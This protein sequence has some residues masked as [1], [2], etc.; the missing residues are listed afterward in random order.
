MTEPDPKQTAR[1]LLTEAHPALVGLSHWIHANPELGYEEVLAAGWI[2]DWMR[3]AGFYVRVGVAGM[4]TALI[5]T[6]GAGRFHVALCAEYDALPAVG[7]ACGHN[8]I[9]AS[10][11]GAAVALAAVADELDL[12]VTLFGTPAEEGGG[13]KIRLIEAGEFEGVHAAL[14]VHPGPD[15]ILEPEI[16]GVRQ[17]T[18]TYTGREA[19]AAAFPELGVNAADAL[20]IAQVAIGALRQHI[21]AGD[22]IHGIVTKGGDAPNIVPAHTTAAY[23][24]RSRT[25]DGLE[26]L[27][28]RV[29]RCFEAGALA[30]GCELVIQR[31]VDYLPV[32]HD[33]DLIEL[34]ARNAEEIGRWFDPSARLVASTD[35]GDVSHVVPS[36]HPMIGIASRPAVNHQPAFADAAVAHAADQAV[37]DG[38]LLLAW[39]AI[40]AAAS[41]DLRTR[42]TGLPARQLEEEAWVSQ[43]ETS[44]WAAAS[45]IEWGLAPDSVDDRRLEFATDGFEPDS[46]S[47]GYDDLDAGAPADGVNAP[48]EWQPSTA[49]AQGP[50]ADSEAPSEDPEPSVP[51]AAADPNRGEQFDAWAAD[52]DAAIASLEQRE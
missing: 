29:E 3:S 15:D 12:R 37:F 13:G 49:D 38:A 17:L 31:E 27:T 16:L 25:R 11:V 18:V 40:D 52:Y 10:S 23:M 43:D 7:H 22:R 8:V 6:A 42:L 2:A 47:L 41:P 50:D 35:M 44:G 39:T 14:M 19:H 51:D 46:A 48:D 33:P 9:A 1:E 4:E 34:Y 20:T 45:V 26:A 32:I 36:I 5:A 28:E 30:T 24:V 21:T